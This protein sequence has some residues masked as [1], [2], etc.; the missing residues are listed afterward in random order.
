MKELTEEEIAKME[1]ERRVTAIERRKIKISEPRFIAT[2][3]NR[4]AYEMG[5][6]GWGLF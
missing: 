1:H 5:L 6:K 4:L 2:A 3:T